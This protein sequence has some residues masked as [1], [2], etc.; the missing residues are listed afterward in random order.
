MKSKS[1]KVKIMTGILLASMAISGSNI[2]FAANTTS[3]TNNIKTKTSA[4]AV[5]GSNNVKTKLSTLVAAG[6]ITSAQSTAIQTALEASHNDKQD[7]QGEKGENRGP[8][9]QLD[10]LITD[11]TITLA[12][13]TA[14]ETALSSA[15]KTETGAATQFDALVAAG[16]ITSAQATTIQTAF[17]AS[18]NDKQDN[19]GENRGPSDQFDNKRVSSFPSNTSEVQKITSSVIFQ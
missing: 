7:N 1:I 5:A 2:V 15:D 16:T 6:T 4:L 18:H 8:S 12:Q 10:A 9:G 14:I 17:K 19:Q 11:G 13:S 3:G